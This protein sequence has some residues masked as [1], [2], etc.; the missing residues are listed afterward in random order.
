MCR[1][2][3]INT[4]QRSTVDGIAAHTGLERFVVRAYFVSPVSYTHLALFFEVGLF[5]VQG[6]DYNA[7][8]II[9]QSDM[10]EF[11]FHHS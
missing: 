5:I 1:R 8:F 10:V 7:V 4:V 3:R 9:V 11:F 6:T 2:D